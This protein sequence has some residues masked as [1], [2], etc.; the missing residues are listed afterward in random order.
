MEMKIAGLMLA[1]NEDWVIGMSARAAL[2]W[3]DLLVIFDHASTD[4]TV[5]IVADLMLEYPGRVCAIHEQNPVWLEM[6]YRNRMLTV[7]RAG[8][9]THIATID[10]DEILTGNLVEPI[11]TIAEQIPDGQIYSPRW[12]QCRKSVDLYHVS[13]TWAT[14]RAS[15]MFRDHM[16]Y[17]WT[18]QG[19]ES[20]D[21]HHRHPMSLV[22]IVPWRH[23]GPGGLMHLQMVSDRRLRAKQA[24]YKM[25]EVI[26]WP[27]KRTFDEINSMHDLTTFGAAAGH[28]PDMALAKTPPE[29]WAGYAPLLRH[30]HIYA[31]P[32]QEAEV[33]RLWELHGPDKFAGLDLYGVVA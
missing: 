21:H 23:G 30:L 1:R 29:W 31:E 26:R 10:A 11:R 28:V 15:L 18:A 22:P 19:P 16:R 33:R 3:C 20:Y 5:S 4:K 14:Q 2:M 9:A 7:A 17:H 25:N 27:G 13:G 8:G 12:I 32:W 6:A 24:L